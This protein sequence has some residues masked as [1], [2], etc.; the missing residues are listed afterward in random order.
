VGV[1]PNWLPARVRYA[2]CGFKPECPHGAVRQV[3]CISDIEA[4]EMLRD[5]GWR[6][7]G[8]ASRILCPKCRIERL[9]RCNGYKI[10]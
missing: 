8:D 10:T 9:F 3:T 2:R 7:S 6:V 4:I 1:D 5:L